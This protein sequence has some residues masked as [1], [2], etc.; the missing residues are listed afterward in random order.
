MPTS[1]TDNRASR[2]AILGRVRKALGK[3]GD[4][5]PARRRR[6]GVRRSARARPASR[7][8][9]GPRR[10][11]HAARDRHGEHRR[12]HRRPRRTFR[13]RSRATSTRSRCR[14][15]S[16]RR[17][18]TRASAGRS[19]PI[20]TGRAPGCGSRRGRRVGDDRL[21]ITGCFCAIAET[22]TLVVLSGA[23]TPTA[24]T[25]LPDTHV[26]VVARRPHRFRH[27]GGLR[28]DPP[29]ARRAA[30]RGEPDLRVRRA[31][32]TSSRRSWSARTGRSACTS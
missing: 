19:S 5:S 28:A 14:P 18:R 4:R 11:L 20:S 13:P 17:S 25:L 26:A 30:A 31:P 1:L 27:G 16:R 29:R 24:T 2:D 10:A 9:G 3:T 21:G 15:R 23:D 12:A 7:H 6:E 8:A 32:A 22:G